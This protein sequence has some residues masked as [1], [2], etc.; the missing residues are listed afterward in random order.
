MQHNFKYKLQALSI[1]IENFPLSEVMDWIE[2]NI[3]E[4][5][6]NYTTMTYTLGGP[7][8]FINVEEK[9]IEGHCD[10]SSLEMYLEMFREV[11]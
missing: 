6:D 9:N 3:V 10:T 4:I 1:E 11:A 5:R 2:E 7:N 8:I